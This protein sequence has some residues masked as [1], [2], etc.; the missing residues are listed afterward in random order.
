MKKIIY[1]FGVFFDPED[2][3]IKGKLKNVICNPHITFEFLP[4][5]VPSN[6][7]GEKVTVT[8]IGYGN[9]GQNEGL[10]VKLPHYVEDYYKNN[11]TPHITLSIAEGAKA[12]NT[13]NLVFT[14]IRPVTITG[15]FG[16]FTK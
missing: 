8:V 6:L 1:Y 3:P 15:Q 4:E 16:I 5:Q 14:E 7:L 11:A 2:L 13:K 12:V 10:T 9:D